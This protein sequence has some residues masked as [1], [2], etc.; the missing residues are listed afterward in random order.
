MQT[1]T[2]REQLVEFARQHELREDWHEPDEQN[3]DAYV[4]GG[5]LDN[6]HTFPT[7]WDHRP[8]DAEPW[9]AGALYSELTVILR[10]DGEPVAAV[11]LASLLAF[12]G[13]WD[14]PS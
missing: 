5:K 3:V 4:D 6:A 2:T 9:Q 8:G 13:G 1:I 14:G 7:G 12:A 11:N 10:C